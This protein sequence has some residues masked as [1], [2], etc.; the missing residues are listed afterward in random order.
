M[1]SAL[2]ISLFI[3]VSGMCGVLSLEGIIFRGMGRIVPSEG[4]SRDLISKRPWK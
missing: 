1:N 4:E 3:K 2:N